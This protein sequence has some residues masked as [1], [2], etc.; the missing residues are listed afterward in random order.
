VIFEVQLIVVLPVVRVHN[1]A[2]DR[3]N[4]LALGFVEMTHALRAQSPIDFIDF[5]TLIDRVIGTL[6][7][8]HVTVDAFIV[9]QKCHT[10]REPN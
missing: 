2:F 6:G 1:D 3:T 4:N 7:F 5:F 10:R 8:A 9:D